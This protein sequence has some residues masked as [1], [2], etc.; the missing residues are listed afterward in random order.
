MNECRAQ[1]QGINF[2]HSFGDR[3]DLFGKKAESE[4]GCKKVSYS[5][6]LLFVMSSRQRLQKSALKAY[7]LK[8]KL[9]QKA[10][11]LNGLQMLATPLLWDQIACNPV[12]PVGKGSFSTEHATAGLSIV[13]LTISKINWEKRGI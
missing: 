6:T 7:I 10:F 8:R 9:C 5:C 12:R 11:A 1:L 2:C 4:K 13:L 3:L